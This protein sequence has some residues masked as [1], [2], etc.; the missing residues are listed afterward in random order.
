[1]RNASRIPDATNG[2][3]RRMRLTRALL[4]C[5]PLSM[6]T[7]PAS[8]VVID[9]NLA[10]GAFNQSPFQSGG[11]FNHSHTEFFGPQWT[12]SKLSLGDIPPIGPLYVTP[13]LTTSGKFG[14]EFGY[15]LSGGKLDLRYPVSSRVSLPDAVRLD[16]PVTVSANAAVNTSGFSFARATLDAN[17]VLAPWVPLAGS[18]TVGHVP[19]LKTTFPSATAYLDLVAEFSGS[20]N[21]SA[22]YPKLIFDP[23]PK[24]RSQTDQV[25]NLKL[26]AFAER[27]T[28]FELSRAGITT[29]IPGAAIP[30]GTAIPIIPPNV[31][32]TTFN[33]PDLKTSGGLDGTTLRAGGAQNVANLN[34]NVLQLLGLAFPPLKAL[35]GNVP[36][37]VGS[38]GYTLLRV[39]A[40]LDLNL[41]QDFA[42]SATPV[43][44]L[45]FDT[46]VSVVDGTTWSAPQQLIPLPASGDLQMRLP[47]GRL[48]TPLDAQ[49]SYALFN[50]LSND[51]KL[52]LD[53]YLQASA[54]AAR[55]NLDL[56]PVQI[57]QAVGPVIGPIGPRGKLA[58]FD[59]FS[60]NFGV[61]VNSIVTKPF[62]IAVEASPRTTRARL[63]NRLPDGTSIYTIEERAGELVTGNM[64][65]QGR[66]YQDLGGGTVFLASVDVTSQGRNHGRL[67]CV[68]CREVDPDPAA[69]STEF[70][71]DGGGS[72]YIN[73]FLMD[74]LSPPSGPDCDT[75][76]E[77]FLTAHAAV[78]DATIGDPELVLNRFPEIFPITLVAVP[79]PGTAW[80]FGL[81][82][83]AIPF[84]ATARRRRK[85]T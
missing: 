74:V 21:A 14:A 58:E 4:L 10:F 64:S 77:D 81:G 49:L 41:R 63:V 60:D 68:D 82:A 8:A 11:V 56:G 44:F 13:S 15:A 47:G 54:L 75:C 34:M 19:S 6:A 48:G 23:L 72:S 51:T 40:G 17:P 66:E 31:L 1:M 30:F 32:T 36:L 50:E 39:D 59:I 80:L 67:F 84:A 53:G 20:I 43:P 24:I 61:N 12:N 25:L 76:L 28:V 69:V 79:E 26:P 73:D 55:L 46:P 52:V 3:C 35:E 5:A 27:L 7:A 38:V 22:T 85:R 2:Y 83:L 18:G 16:V 71:L 33:Y 57:N 45:Y 78:A 42:F 62:Q 9:H 70:A 37:G 65:V 29:A